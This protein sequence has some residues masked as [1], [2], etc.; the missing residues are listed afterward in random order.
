MINTDS[1]GPFFLVKQECFLLFK[2]F[3]GGLHLFLVSYFSLLCR[4]LARVVFFAF[5]VAVLF[6]IFMSSLS[7]EYCYARENANAQRMT[8][9]FSA[10][11]T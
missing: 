2:Q 5:D 3:E 4:S 11:D 1:S 9:C 8:V 10:A 6:D 7:E